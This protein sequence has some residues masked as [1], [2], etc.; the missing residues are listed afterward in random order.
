[1]AILTPNKEIVLNSVLVKEFFLTKNNPNKI[2][3][4]TS[5]IDKLRGI[6]I[7]NTGWIN[8]SSSTTPAE[9]YTR[10]TYNGNMKDVRVHFYV[11]N[12]CAWQNL[13]T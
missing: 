3:M 12:I 11:D 10:A 13:P 8:V 7:H 1:M 5:K 4:P 9:Q 6:T 2:A